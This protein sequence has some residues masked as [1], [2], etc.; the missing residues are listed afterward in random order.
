MAVS[1]LEAVGPIRLVGLMRQQNPTLDPEGTTRGLTKQW[2]DFIT[3]WHEPTAPTDNL[4][5]H[6][7]MADGATRFDYFS[8][9]RCMLP[10]PDG[11]QE[12]LLPA[13]TCAV[14]GYEG[15]VVGLRAFVQ[16]VF[17]K[18][19]PD[20]GL[21]LLPHTIDAPELIERYRANFDVATSSGGIE[22][23]VPVL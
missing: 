21:T 17:A 22:I 6:I 19:L 2:R 13:M 4:G 7:R 20:A 14:F 16:K 8:G 9:T 11:F 3:S 10:A 1:R 5:V 15:H 18:L 12:L 23:L